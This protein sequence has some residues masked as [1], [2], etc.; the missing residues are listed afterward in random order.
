MKH[1]LPQHKI[2]AAVAGVLIAG[3]VTVYVF[4]LGPEREKLA[5]ARDKKQS[6]RQELVKKDW[7]LDV[8]QLRKAREKERAKLARLQRRASEILQES[9]GMF[10]SKMERLYPSK[11]MFI[12]QVSRLDYQEEYNRIEQELRDR[13]VNLHGEILGVTEDTSS[14]FIYQL[15]LKLWTVEIVADK[16]TESGLRVSKLPQVTKYDR[17]GGKVAASQIAVLPMQAYVTQ[18]DAG[19]PYLL[20]FPVKVLVE[21]SMSAFQGFLRSLHG[22]GRKQAANA[23][24]DEGDSAGGSNEDTAEKANPEA[25]PFV[26]VSHMEVKKMT[27]RKG[28]DNIAREV[29]VRLIV[30]CFFRMG[31]EKDVE[32]MEVDS[33][34][35]ETQESSPLGI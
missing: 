30:S 17:Y 10:T 11:D 4:G 34:G 1:I 12:E 27:P 7:P 14:P 16:V 24:G 23:S 22:S 26:P 29:Q 5:K 6:I 15:M 32:P 13:G 21:G 28:G 2:L 8:D 25:A 3:T 9:T 20:E 33:E 35:E 31:G 19:E 18:E